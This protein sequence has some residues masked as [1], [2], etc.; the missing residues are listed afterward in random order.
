MPEN[1]VK[2]S[3]SAVEVDSFEFLLFLIL[4]LVL[5]GSQHTFS[6]HFEV[7]SREIN[8]VN[9]F[10]NMFSTTANGLKSLVENGKVH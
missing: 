10:L 4:L 5:M 8:R 3:T 9:S 6:S 1:T 2:E 7:L